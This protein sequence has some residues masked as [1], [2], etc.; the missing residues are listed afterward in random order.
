MTSLWQVL[1]PPPKRVDRHHYEVVIPDEV[2]QFDF[3]TPSDMLY[4]NKYKH[5]LSGIDVASR[6]KVAMPMK[7]KQAADIANMIS[8]IYKVGA[9]NYP[10]VFQCDNGGKFKA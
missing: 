2:H 7:T 6:Y 8:D 4:G 3:Y 9:L 5:I 1:S 10:K